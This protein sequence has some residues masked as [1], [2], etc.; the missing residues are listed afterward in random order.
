MTGVLTTDTLSPAR[1][2]RPPVLMV[3]DEPGTTVGH[4]VVDW[5]VVT[6]VIV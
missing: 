3:A 5:L 2:E 1:M 4:V 6:S